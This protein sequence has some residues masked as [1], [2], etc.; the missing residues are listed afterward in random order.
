MKEGKKRRKLTAKFGANFGDGAFYQY[1]TKDFPNGK[2]NALG[3]MNYIIGYIKNFRQNKRDE[4][5]PY[6]Y[7]AAQYESQVKNSLELYRAIGDW[8]VERAENVESKSTV[9]NAYLERAIDAYARAYNF[10][11]DFKFD[12][13]KTNLYNKLE[14]LFVSRY[15][16]KTDVKSKIEEFAS[17]VTNKPLPEMLPIK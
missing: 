5:I 12:K 4:A 3:W 10:A 6:F 14:L 16:N 9:K 1:E 13:S 17:G 11:N 8:Y 7:K 15:G 2:E